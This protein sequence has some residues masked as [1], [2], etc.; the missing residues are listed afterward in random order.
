[1]IS[2][3]ARSTAGWQPAGRR[4]QN[5]CRASRCE[6]ARSKEARSRNDRI[7]R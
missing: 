5:P 3:Q 6:Q 7:R 1:L 2:A 4:Y